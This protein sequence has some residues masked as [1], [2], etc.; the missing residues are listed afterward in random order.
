MQSAP[1]SDGA[2]RRRHVL[3]DVLAHAPAVVATHV[4]TK[5]EPDASAVLEADRGRAEDAEADA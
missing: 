5:R 2:V 1:G 4:E 3:E